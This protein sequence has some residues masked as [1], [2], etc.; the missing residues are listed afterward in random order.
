MGSVQNKRPQSDAKN[1]DQRSAAYK[2]LVG[3]LDISG[4]PSQIAQ[5]TLRGEVYASDRF[6]KRMSRFIERPT[7][8]SAYGGDGKSGACPY[9][10][11]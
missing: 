9:M 3:K 4:Q 2:A 5:T 10:T 1:I 8:L 6:H 7:K 11:P